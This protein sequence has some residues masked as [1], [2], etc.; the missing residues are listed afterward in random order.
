M[1][2]QT[3]E[4]RVCHWS[5]K[6]DLI[7]MLSKSIQVNH[8]SYLSIVYQGYSEY[9]FLVKPVSPCFQIFDTDCEALRYYIKQEQYP[10]NKLKLLSLN[11][12]S[13]PDVYVLQTLKLAKD[14]MLKKATTQQANPP[15]IKAMQ[16]LIHTMHR[17][18]ESES[19]GQ[20]QTGSISNAYISAVMVIMSYVAASMVAMTARYVH[21]ES[22]EHLTKL[23][24]IRVN[25][26]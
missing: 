21:F 26:L 14:L 22:R 19:P 23:N 7:H 6:L 18:L 16:E 10:Y 5:D 15:K 24:Q 20:A 25:M 3:D 12:Q 4:T 1:H 2:T 17:R 11:C 13:S 8:L 9:V